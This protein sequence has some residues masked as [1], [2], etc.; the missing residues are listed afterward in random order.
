M[1]P[2]RPRLDLTLPPPPH[3]FPMPPCLPTCSM[4]LDKFVPQDA[5]IVFVEY[6]LNDG[7]T[8]RAHA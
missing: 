5:D 7:Y 4:C 3:P 8:V 6:I 1:V 2:V